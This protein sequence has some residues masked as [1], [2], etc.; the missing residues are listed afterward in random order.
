MGRDYTYVEDIV[1]GV[2]ASLEYGLPSGGTPFDI[3]N[4]GNSHPVKLKELIAALEVATGRSASRSQQ[5]LQ[6]GDV[7]LTWA[8]IEKAS[9]LLGYQP[10]VSLEEGLKRFVAW[11]RNSRCE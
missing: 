11:Y 1:S 7:P 3:F 9:R 6:P 10:Q 5:P 2:L 8:N 4:L